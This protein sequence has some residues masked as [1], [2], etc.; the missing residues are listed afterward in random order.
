MACTAAWPGPCK[1]WEGFPLPD[2]VDLRIA[3]FCAAKTTVVPLWHVGARN[4]WQ[5]VARLASP[6]VRL[7]QRPDEITYTRP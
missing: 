2:A 4:C 7:R 1:P 5:L 6:G 3:S